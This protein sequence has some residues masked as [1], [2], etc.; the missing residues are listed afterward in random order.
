LTLAVGLENLDRL[1]LPVAGHFSH[2]IVILVDV[3]PG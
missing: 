2:S 1:F 3:P